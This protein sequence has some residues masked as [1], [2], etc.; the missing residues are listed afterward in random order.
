MRKY[1]FGR[2]PKFDRRSRKFPI[3]ALLDNLKPRSYTW[4][5]PVVL[6]QGNIGACCGFSVS[7]EAAAKPCPV[8]NITNKIALGVYYRAQELDEFPGEDYEGSS[9]L[10]A[11]KAGKEKGWYKEYRWAFD[12]EDLALAVGHHGPAVLG[13]NWMTGMM[14]P[15]SNGLIKA[16]G[17]TEGGHAILCNAVSVKKGLYR[18]HN[19]WGTG[20]GIGGHCFISRDDIAKLLKSRGEACIPIVRTK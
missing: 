20:Y 10:G 8:P 12:E 7:Q 13:I 18:L 1:A 2:I 17:Y 4:A 15:D 3:R 5:C 19:S 6:D 9:V 11:I 14:T 16:T